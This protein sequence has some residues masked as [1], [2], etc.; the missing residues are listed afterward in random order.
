LS[1]IQGGLVY[2]KETYLANRV[3]TMVCSPKV[4]IFEDPSIKRGLASRSF[5]SEGVRTSKRAIISDGVLNSYMLSTYSA[6][7]LGLKATG[8][9]GGYGNILVSPGLLSESEMIKQM[10]TGLWLTELSGQGIKMTTGDYSRG[11][12]G[13]WIENGEIAYPV[14]EFT[15]SGNLDRMFQS[16]SMIGSEPEQ[17]KAIITPGFVLSEMTLSGT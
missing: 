5:D 13:L 2:R 4:L 11:A 17:N 15:I 14:S 12:S 8:H 10:G 1:G 3:D 6:N 7:K 16:I 9:S